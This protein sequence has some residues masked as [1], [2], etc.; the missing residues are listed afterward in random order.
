MPELFVYVWGVTELRMRMLKVSFGRYKL[1]RN[2][3]VIHFD[4]TLEPSM[5]EKSIHLD[6]LKVNRVSET[7]E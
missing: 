2:T 5:G 1:T 6:K 4:Y 3:H 7:E